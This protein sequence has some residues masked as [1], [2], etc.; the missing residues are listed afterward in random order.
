MNYLNSVGK[1]G[2]IFCNGDN[3]TFPLWYLHEVEEYRTDAR[4]CNLSYLQTEWYVDQMV[5]Q[6]Y[7]SEPLPIKWPRERYASDAGSHA[8]I[9][10]RKEIELYCNKIIFHRFP[11][12]CITTRMC[13]RIRYRLSK[14][15][16][17]CGQG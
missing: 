10:T 2:I 14:R 4:A 1:N 9:L 11:I 15:W 7:D 12:I 3:D 13:L 17:I 8:Y 5:R 6:A 16:K